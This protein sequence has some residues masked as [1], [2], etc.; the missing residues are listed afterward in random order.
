MITS[1]DYQGWRLEWRAHWTHASQVDE[2]M[3]VRVLNMDPGNVMRVL[4]WFS[5]RLLYLLSF[6]M[7]HSGS[8][9]TTSNYQS[10]CV[11]SI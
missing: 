6:P 11:I 2:L 4:E 3:A 5:V 8:N 7:D 9:M 1:D 10:E